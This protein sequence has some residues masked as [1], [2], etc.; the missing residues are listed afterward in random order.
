MIIDIKIKTKDTK[1]YVLSLRMSYADDYVKGIC[2][3]NM[4]QAEKMHFISLVMAA[5]IYL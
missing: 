4:M 2:T 3:I 5:R 1:Q